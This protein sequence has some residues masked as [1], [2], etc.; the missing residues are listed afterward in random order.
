[1]SLNSIVSVQN[2]S[3]K[4]GFRANHSESAGGPSS[5]QSMFVQPVDFL[6]LGIKIEVRRR[7]L[8]PVAAG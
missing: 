2:L 3:S 6:R 7:R 1:M 5:S 8:A 4:T